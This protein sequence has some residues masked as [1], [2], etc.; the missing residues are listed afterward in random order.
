M[1]AFLASLVL[2]LGTLFQGALNPGPME[3]FPGDGA[4][5]VGSEGVHDPTIIEFGGRYFCFHTSGNTFATVRSSTDLKSWKIEGPVLPEQPAWLAARYQ[6]KS[7]WAPD[8]V[9]MGKSLRMYYSA[10]NWGTNNSVIGLAECANFDPLHP[11]TGWV[12]KGLV[13][14]SKKD[15]DAFNAIDPEV[16]V[17]PNGRQW[18]AFGSYFGGIY[19]VELDAATGK[20]SL[21]SG[22]AAPILLAKNTSEPGNP[23]EGAA[24][25]RRGDTYYLFVSYGLAAQGVRSTYRIMVGRSKSITGPYLDMNGK[26]MAEG[27]F[28]NVLKGSPP[29]F[30]PGH[31]DVL[32]LSDGRWVMPY[33]FYDGRHYWTQDKWGRP[34]LQIRDLLWS[35]DGWPLP[36]LPA[37]FRSPSSQRRGVRGE[38]ANEPPASSDLF[39]DTNSKIRSK[40]ILPLAPTVLPRRGE[41]DRN[42]A[43]KWLHQVDFGEPFVIEIKTDGTIV[44][45]NGNGKWS[46][47]GDQLTL[48]WPKSESPSERRA[49]KE[50]DWIDQLTFFYGH[51]Y[52]VGRNQSGLVIRGA[53]Q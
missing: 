26:S 46:V 12:D 39:F 7:I 23:L 11:L 41:E 8:V 45:P 37:G 32:Q 44:S 29:M 22:A 48:K 47:D 19:M 53:R 20:M 16:V 38:G 25:C 34:A 6:H 51:T 3:I 1:S 13:L 2:T 36:G 17:E 14:E 5:A 40:L 28:S 4:V 18:M 49:G 35:T 52:Y 42:F 33:H 24:I 50:G 15:I 43:G 31:C 9:V 10:S 21:I 30:S 27:G